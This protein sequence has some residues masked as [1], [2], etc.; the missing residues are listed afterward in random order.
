[1]I[2]SKQTVFT[3]T[4]DA[5]RMVGGIVIPF[6]GYRIRIGG[7]EVTEKVKVTVIGTSYDLGITIPK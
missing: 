4:Y 2:E 3:T 1:M 5:V 7:K 6:W